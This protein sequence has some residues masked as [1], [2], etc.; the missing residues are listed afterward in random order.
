MP[1]LSAK[2]GGVAIAA[3]LFFVGIG[4]ILFDTL[5]RN[6]RLEKLEEQRRVLREEIYAMLPDV[7]ESQQELNIYINET[8]G[9]TGI[10]GLDL[11]E[12]NRVK[13]SIQLKGDERLKDK[14]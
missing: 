10:S 11:N 12:L 8:F 6:P 2:R 13:K 5:T 7:D 1:E 3:I 4:L 9:K 14:V